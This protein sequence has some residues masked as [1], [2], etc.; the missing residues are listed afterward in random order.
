MNFIWW[1]GWLGVQSAGQALR[2]NKR[3]TLWERSE[4]V[5]CHSAVFAIAAYPGCL[6]SFLPL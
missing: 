3:K 4:A 5:L 1:L 2:L 6:V